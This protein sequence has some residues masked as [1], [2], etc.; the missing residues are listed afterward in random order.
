MYGNAY[1]HIIFEEG[2]RV[3]PER[4]KDI[5]REAKIANGVGLPR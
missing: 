2:R 1:V 5:E 3:R 4:M